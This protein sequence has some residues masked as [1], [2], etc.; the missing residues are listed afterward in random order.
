MAMIVAPGL[1]SDFGCPGM[2]VARSISLVLPESHHGQRT[3]VSPRE[4]IIEGVREL[5]EQQYLESVDDRSKDEYRGL[6]GS[7]QRVILKAFLQKLTG[8]SD[9]DLWAKVLHDIL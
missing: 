5:L 7:E 4:R 2:L 8:G 3:L 6:N 9:A 1:L